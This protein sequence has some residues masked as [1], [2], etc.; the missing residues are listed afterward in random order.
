MNPKENNKL[1]RRKSKH[2]FKKLLRILIYTV[3]GLILLLAL[4]ILLIRTP[5]VQQWITDKATAYVTEKTGAH[6]S[7]DKLYITFSGNLWLEGLYLE[8]LD[9]DTLL[10]SNSLEA[11]VA[12]RPLF[13]NHLKLTKLDWSGVNSNVKRDSAGG[14]NFNFLF[15]ALVGEPDEQKELEEGV[16]WKISPAPV[17]LNNIRFSLVDNYEGMDM[18]LDL[19]QLN[20]GLRP[21]TT[22][23]TGM[24]FSIVSAEGINYKMVQR[25][26][27]LYR[28]VEEDNKPTAEEGKMFPLSIESLT[29]REIGVQIIDSVNESEMTLRLEDHHSQKLA[30]YSVDSLHLMHHLEI[31]S[32]HTRGLTFFSESQGE[33]EEE[34]DPMV[35][36][37]KEKAPAVFDWPNWVVQTGELSFTA[38][39][40]KVRER[41]IPPSP[42]QF[43]A[44]DID[45]HLDSL[46]IPEF[47]LKEER[48]STRLQKLVVRD[49][50]GLDIREFGFDLVLDESGSSITQLKAKTAYSE[51]SGQIDVVYPGIAAMLNKPEKANF[52]IDLPAL[53]ISPKDIAIVNPSWLEGFAG[54]EI[55]AHPI[56]LNTLIEGNAELLTIKNFSGRVARHTRLRLNGSL[57]NVLDAEKISFDAPYLYLYTTDGDLQLLIPPDTSYTMPSTLFIVGHAK[58]TTK[59]IEAGFD[60][61]IPHGDMHLHGNITHLDETPV[62]HLIADIKTLDAAFYTDSLGPEKIAGQIELNGRGFAPNHLSAQLQLSLEE[63]QYQGHLLSPLELYANYE[64]KKLE[65]QFDL[66]SELTKVAM[67][68]WGSMDSTA[69]AFDLHSDIRQLDLNAL[70]VEEEQFLAAADITASGHGNTGIFDGHF[71]LKGIEVKKAETTYRVDSLIASVS[72]DPESSLVAVNSPLLSASLTANHPPDKVIS[73]L[74]AH[75]NSYWETGSIDTAL[76]KGLETDLNILIPQTEFLTEVIFPDLEEMEDIELRINYREINKS[77][78]GELSAP[79][80]NY[81]GTEVMGMY[82]LV[83]SNRDSLDFSTGF[84]RVVSGP[85]D[86]QTTNISGS[87][88]NSILNTRIDVLDLD[89]SQMVLM[90]LEWQYT[91]DTLELHIQT[92]DLVFNEFP[93]D[94]HPDNRLFLAEDYLNIEEFIFSRNHHSLQFQSHEGRRND[95][96]KILFNDISLEGLLG[97]LN[98]EDPMAKGTI[99]GFIEADHIFGTPILLADLEVI[100][101]EALDIALGHLK[102]KIENPSDRQYTLQSS[103]SGG[104]VNLTADG[105]FNLDPE[106][107]MLYDA[108]LDLSHLN[109][110]IIEKFTE[111]AIRNSSGSLSG[112]VKTTGSA[113]QI[114]YRGF[115]GFNDVEFEMTETG[116]VFSIPEERIDFS[117]SDI[118]FSSFSIEDNDGNPTEINGSVGIENPINPNFDLTIVSRN[119]KFLESTRQDNDFIYGK[120]IADLN[121]DLTGNLNRPNVNARVSLKRG[122]EITTIIP[123]SQVDIEEREGVVRIE[124]RVDGQVVRE[125]EPE[126]EQVPLFTGVDLEAIINI[127]PAVIFRIVIDERAGD[128]L[129]VAGEANLSFDM[130]T[131][132]NMSLAGIYELNRGFYEMRMYEIVRRR[133]ELQ[134]GSR[135][136]WTG[137]PMAAEMQITAIHRV[138]TSAL[139]LMADQLGGADEMTRTQYRQELPFDV[140]LELR[141]ELMRPDLTFSLDMPESAQGALGGN[142]YNRIRQLNTME[143]ELNTQVFSLL[144]LGRFLPP[145][146]ASEESRVFDAGAMARSSASS[147]L[148]GQLNALSER[149]VRGVDL[150]FDLESFTDYQT[151]RP[152]DRTQLNVRMRRSLLDE[153]LTI[154]V[155]GQIDLEG[156][157]SEERQRAADILGDVSVE[158]RLTE[159]GRWGLRGFRQNKYEGV[160]EGQVIIT[161]VSLLF[162][163][164]FNSFAEIFSG[165]KKDDEKD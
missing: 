117:Q 9:R 93:W 22:A 39:R 34:V 156:S 124:R 127:D 3:F 60:V 30:L 48:L 105:T 111:G 136:I 145:G 13:N 77:I 125:E 103:L 61:K 128:M 134:A 143:S 107:G 151:G 88:L 148:S 150:D 55:V 89:S 12:I 158:Y 26:P 75:V 4:L 17:N 24:D 76:V 164:D 41:I 113:D 122:T 58:G 37:D 154:Q 79:Y 90:G 11:G 33:K 73:G 97:F 126:V 140:Y 129:E 5:S 135:L 165:K 133:F 19:H 31:G 72:Y 84:E 35:V 50:S 98:P 53:T 110:K 71:L 8:D 138:R 63:L 28:K 16:I 46:I 80:I 161:G 121:I 86:I 32:A 102:A 69:Y 7:I 66:D 64:N 116:S 149:Y 144:V 106:R 109:F 56:H 119:F 40:I 108:T 57:S 65:F 142:V 159:D 115:I 2:W 96:L 153:R 21:L 18:Y 82:G 100:D 87:F 101:M 85:A 120:A 130:D 1:P 123:E 23:M 10:F 163:R 25:A 92:E 42:G 51:I 104:D 70:G 132:G 91:D 20:L 49:H 78:R 74:W 15:D 162:N 160:L 38:H 6:A 94:V 112:E 147:L 45:L 54:S 62:Y 43:N 81:A 95:Y 44:S 146:I 131:R 67:E 114:N 52:T 157:E 36:V 99:N 118:V 68:G 152:E 139:D 155:G 27:S 59:Q 137:D 141:G 83:N 14:Y 47:R 29:L